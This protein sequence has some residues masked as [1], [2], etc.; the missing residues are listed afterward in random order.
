MEEQLEG[1]EIVRCWLT[2][3][4]PAHGAAADRALEG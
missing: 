1:L 4:P 2:V 3:L